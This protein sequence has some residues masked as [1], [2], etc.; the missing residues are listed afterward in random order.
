[1]IFGHHWL[2]LPQLSPLWTR[3]KDCSLNGDAGEMWNWPSRRRK[4]KESA[5]ALRQ[6]RGTFAVAV[7]S[8]ENKRRHIE[9]LMKRML[10]ERRS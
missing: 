7:V 1:M 9:E 10:E 3:P 4:K 2:P 6:A 8:L 5:E